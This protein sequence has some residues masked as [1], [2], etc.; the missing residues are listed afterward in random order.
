MTP[1]ASGYLDKARACLRYARVNLSVE[2]ANDAGRNAYLAAFH[3]AQAL[4]FERTGKVAKSHQGVHAEFSRLAKDE[5][6]ITVEMRRFLSQAY[7]LKA[8]ADYEMGPDAVVPADRAASA[9]DDTARF[10]DG[11]SP[12][13]GS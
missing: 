1:E 13:L 10:V 5:P 6:G 4:I 9:L 11:I 3:A 2:L 8:V 7:D 12:L